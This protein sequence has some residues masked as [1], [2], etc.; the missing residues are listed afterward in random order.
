MNSITKK[1]LND[2]SLFSRNTI[3]KIKDT[4]CKLSSVKRKIITI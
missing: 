1:F 2:Y 3:T 4:T